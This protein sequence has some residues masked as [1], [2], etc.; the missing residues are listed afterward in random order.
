METTLRVSGF[1]VFT[2]V[3]FVLIGFCIGIIRLPFR[4]H[5]AEE[6]VLEFGK[7]GLFMRRCGVPVVIAGLL[8]FVGCG[9]GYLISMV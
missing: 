5:S 2:G 7:T 8:G 3:N 1:L 6:D 4:G 9:V